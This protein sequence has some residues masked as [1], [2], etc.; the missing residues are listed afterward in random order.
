MVEGTVKGPNYWLVVVEKETGDF[1]NVN[2][3][4]EPGTTEEDIKDY[5]ESVNPRVRVI[6]N[7]EGIDNRPIPLRGLAYI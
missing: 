7:G 4:Y 6:Y 1:K 3:S 2:I 5:Y